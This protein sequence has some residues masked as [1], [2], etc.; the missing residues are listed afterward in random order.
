MPGEL[1]SEPVLLVGA[2]PMAI[3]YAKVLRHLDHRL[4]VVGRGAESAR[5]FG[6]AAGVTAGT[7][8]LSEQLA[9][10]ET[11]PRMAV[12]SV[13]AMYLA[14]V[15]VELA[16][17]GVRRILVEKPAALDRAELDALLDVVA[18][19]SA[20]ICIGYNRRFLESV[21]RARDLVIEDGG[22]LSVTFDFSEPSRRIGSLAKPQRELETWFYGNS[23]HVIDLALHFAGDCTE[24][25]GAIAGA[26]PWHPDGGVFVG[27]AR[28]V[29]GALVSWHA[30]WM[31]PGRWG[32][33]VVTPER[34]L[35]LQPLER[36]RVQ[37]HHSFDEHD[38]ELDLEIDTAY[39]PGLLRQVRA[40]LYGDESEHLATLDE[41][42]RKWELYETI[43]TGAISPHATELQ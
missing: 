1:M 4:V 13:N 8:P 31:G 42:A 30:N 26:V 22:V 33:N 19:T 9:R 16:R 25:D 40:F 12:V 2:G 23:T 36:L 43:R 28:A 5:R 41:H 17:L 32:V 29:S 18:E 21:R 10:L 34:R 11:V 24:A 27:H 3:E 6:E 7:G 35:I 37:D 14:D 38:I 20:E 15:T 39:K